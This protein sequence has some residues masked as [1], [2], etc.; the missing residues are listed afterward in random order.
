MFMDMNLT[1]RRRRLAR[2]F[3]SAFGSQRG[4]GLI[5]VMVSLLILSIGLLGM[6][7]LQA[8]GINGSQRASFVTEAQLIAQ[9]MVDRIIAT[10]NVSSSPVANID[11]RTGSYGDID[12]KKGDAMTYPS[13]ASGCAPA[14]A[15]LYNE[16]EWLQLITGSSLPRGRGTVLWTAAAAAVPAFYRVQVMWNQERDVTAV[17]CTINNCFQMEVR[18]P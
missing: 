11:I 17:T 4:S 18:L 7:S 1:A 13:C 6:L 14:A 15:K 2:E 3:S 10:T 9:D 5:E 16:D 8:N 12:I